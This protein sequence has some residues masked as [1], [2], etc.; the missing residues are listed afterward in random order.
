MPKPIKRTERFITGLQ[1]LIDGYIDGAGGMVDRDKA[2]FE[3]HAT[4]MAYVESMDSF[5]E[6]AN[7]DAYIQ[8]CALAVGIREDMDG[9]EGLAKRLQQEDLKAKPLAPRIWTPGER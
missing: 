5:V 9:F 3:I 8:V 1:K 4:M 7:P 6:L 2:R